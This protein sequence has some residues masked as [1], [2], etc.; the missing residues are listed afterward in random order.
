MT[1]ISTQ[2]NRLSRR[3]LLFGVVTAGGVA[4][5]SIGTCGFF[6][7]IK[8]NTC[9]TRRTSDDGLSLSE[10][11][12][13][14][15]SSIE[16]FPYALF[17]FSGIRFQAASTFSRYLKFY[18]Y[19]EKVLAS[20]KK[21]IDDCV[22]QIE[23]FSAKEKA[24]AL[25]ATFIYD[26][27]YQSDPPR[28]DHYQHR[29]RN[30]RKYARSLTSTPKESKRPYQT[31]S[32]NL[33]RSE[34]RSYVPGKR[35]YYPN[36]YPVLGFYPEA[37]KFLIIGEPFPD[38]NVDRECCERWQALRDEY[39]SSQEKV[40]SSIPLESDV[41]LSEDDYKSK[42]ARLRESPLWFPANAHPLVVRSSINLHDMPPY[43]K[44]DLRNSSADLS[45]D[46][47]EKGRW[48]EWFK[49]IEECVAMIDAELDLKIPAEK[50]I[51]DYYP[52]ADLFLK[53]IAEFE[54]DTS[55]PLEKIELLTALREYWLSMQIAFDYD[56]YQDYWSVATYNALP[57]PKPNPFFDVAGT[58][59]VTLGQFISW[60]RLW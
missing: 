51:S 56:S 14:E 7:T 17:A 44:K 37:R 30:W 38:R 33:D 46:A 9:R 43:S 42:L 31:S 16:V 21:E 8:R 34:K 35:F 54:N 3:R 23:S 52:D 40:F 15:A 24:L 48:I 53:K 1:R 47:S 6:S 55:T 36:F 11:L 10:Y 20:S 27:V 58:R 45:S 25:F 13:K 12:R 49:N 32:R 59:S 39:K 60:F 4:C 41:T 50:W 2:G 29:Y 26:C 19:K 28:Y 5:A 57:P 22:R 18:R